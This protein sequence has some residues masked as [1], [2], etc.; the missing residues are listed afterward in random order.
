MKELVLDDLVFV[1]GGKGGRKPETPKPET[2]KPENTTT[3]T[4]EGQITICP[5]WMEQCF[6]IKIHPKKEK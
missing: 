4:G 3:V 1:Y 2:P 5:D 6:T